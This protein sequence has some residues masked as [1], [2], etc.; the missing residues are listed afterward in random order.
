MRHPHSDKEPEVSDAPKA[1]PAAL[2]AAFHDTL[3]LEIV[4]CAEGRSTVRLVLGPAHLNGWQAAHGGVVMALLDVAMAQA[5]RSLLPAS[6]APSLVTVEMKTSF[7]RPAEGVL[8]V[9]GLVL[10]RTTTL[11][12]CEATVFDAA[13]RRC[14]HATGTFKYFVSRAVRRPEPPAP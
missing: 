1:H 12:F 2:P 7:M 13:D 10:E 4:H 14:A 5:A 3:G 8:R 6:R 9:E 11:A